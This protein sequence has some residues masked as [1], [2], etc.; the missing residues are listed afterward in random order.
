M[1][2]VD[3]CQLECASWWPIFKS[4]INNNKFVEKDTNI[5]MSFRQ[6]RRTT[7]KKRRRQCRAN[8]ISGLFPMNSM[9][10]TLFAC[11]KCSSRVFLLTHAF[12]HIFHAVFAQKQIGKL[13]GRWNK[14]MPK[15]KWI[16][17]NCF[18]C[19][20]CIL[21]HLFVDSLQQIKPFMFT[22]STDRNL[23][24]STH[25]S[26]SPPSSLSRFCE[27]LTWKFS[28]AKI[29]SIMQMHRKAR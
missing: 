16:L 23:I 15:S 13:C 4:Q 27:I 25:F 22:R 6:K 8:R 21:T 20:Q 9:T 2:S 1:S 3:L 18:E 26:T 11:S 28:T 12:N 19:M 24:K 14:K 17:C 5:V 7:E 29:V 10:N